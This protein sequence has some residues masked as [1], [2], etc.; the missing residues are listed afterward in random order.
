MEHTNR[1]KDKMGFFKKNNKDIKTT[2]S[3]K[4]PSREIDILK[5]RQEKMASSSKKILGITS[6]LSDF[7]VGMDHI[8]HQLLDFSKEISILSQSNMALVEETTAS[9]GEVSQAVVST[10]DTLENL[11]GKSHL[12]VEKNDESIVLLKDMGDLKE[13]VI[14]D[15]EDLSGKFED[16]IEI[17]SEVSKIV[18]G[19][20]QIAEQTNLLALNA[21]I[22]AARAAEH[23]KGF[24]VVAAEIRKL[25]DNT[26]E[27]LQGMD[28]FLDSI[29]KATKEGDASL[30]NTLKSTEDISEKIEVVSKTMEGNLNLLRE[31]ESDIDLI[32][33]DMENVKVS[34]QEISAAM[35]ESSGDAEKLSDMAL[36][37]E[38][39]AI[40]SVE[41]SKNI[42]VID[43]NLSALVKDLFGHLQGS[44]SGVSNHELI[45]IIDNAVRSHLE[46]VDKLGGMLETMSLAPLQTDSDRCVFGHFYKAIEMDN[47]LIKEP[48]L[49]VDKIHHRVHSLGDVFLEDINNVDKEGA[50]ATYKKAQD[51][52]KEMISELEN[53]KTIIEDAE[54][55]A[56]EILK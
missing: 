29:G 14:K 4:A 45:E 36:D 6:S 35:D 27:N 20:K 50:K 1:K 24:S 55:Q 8:S 32:N 33:G 42:A 38:N 18:E 7:D 19:V 12:L 47:D 25:A 31:V 46:W 37:I 48:W 56:I 9:M 51:A 5:E 30:K 41:F 13:E 17:S 11:S 43:Q 34:T 3:V 22:E 15:T 21:A 53:I 23:G 10:R 49:G 2:P 44:G 52:S 54:K 39:N 28:T 26:K 16:L 40:E